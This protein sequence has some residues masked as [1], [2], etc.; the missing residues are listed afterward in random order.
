M[1]QAGVPLVLCMDGEK[2]EGEEESLAR[3]GG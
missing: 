3:G 2:G 1:A